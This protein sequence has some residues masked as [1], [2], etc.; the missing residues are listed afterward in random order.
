MM[1]NGSEKYGP[2]QFDI[3]MEKNGGRNNAYTSRDVTV[4]TDW[5]PTA[6][7]PLMLDMESDRMTSLK[8]IPKMVKSERAVVYSERQM[9]VDD[10]NFGVLMEQLNAAAYM[11]HPY[12][13]P[14]VG[15]ASDIQSWTMDDL[16]AHYRTAY[17]PN[18]CVMVMVGDVAAAEAIALATKYFGKIPRH[19]PPPPVR[20]VEPEQIGE[21]RIT[22][23]R[24]AQVPMQA[25]SFHIP[26]TAHPD[27]WPLEVL[28]TILCTGQSSRLYRAL[29]DRD[30]IAISQ[31]YSMDATLDPGQLVFFV[32][33][34][35]GV[36]L[37]SSEATF[38]GEIERLRT[39]E[40]SAEELQ[41][42]KNQ[43]LT[44]LYREMKTI[45]GRANLLGEYE[46]FSGDYRELFRADQK[47]ANVTG[48]DVQRVAKKY[49]SPENRTYAE[50]RAQ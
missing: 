14:V 47:I 25:Y 13:W 8:L 17:A 4:Y 44:S 28:A 45:S 48:A 32:Q 9:S 19:D 37:R 26:R 5:F 7:L 3:Q 34:K 2:K 21:R 15:W 31:S 10:S 40:P 29:I 23:I 36:D 1:F 6:L 39:A 43:L 16:E 46:I 12:R 49:L 41:K 38:S 50:L 18:N 42:A 27:S 24:P 30:P 11:A 33:P 20:T 35:S 22:V